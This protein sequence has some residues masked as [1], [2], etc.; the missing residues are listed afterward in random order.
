MAMATPRRPAAAAAVAAAIVRLSAA[1]AFGPGANLTGGGTMPLMGYGCGP[2]LNAETIMEALKVGYRHLDTAFSH[3]NHGVVG[4]AIQRSGVPREEIFLT[5]K[6]GG[7][8]ASQRCCFGL[9]EL[10]KCFTDPAADDPN[11]GAGDYIAGRELA[12]VK[13]ALSELGLNYIDLCLIHRPTVTAMEMHA[14]YLPHYSLIGVITTTWVRRWLQA[15]LDAAVRWEGLL[16]GRAR[17]AAAR[18]ESWRQLEDAKRSGL[19]RHIGLSNYPIGV[20]REMEAYA[21]EPVDVIQ[22][23]YTPI[24]QFPEIYA[25]ARERGIALTGYGTLISTGILGQMLNDTGKRL[26]KTGNQV[27]LRWRLQ[28]GVGLLQGTSNPTRMAENLEVQNFELSREDM[29]ELDALGS[30]RFPV[31]FSNSWHDDLDAGPSRGDAVLLAALATVVLLVLAALATVVRCM[32]GRG[33][34]SGAGRK[35]KST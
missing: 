16:G 9:L 19:C 5:T 2:H 11:A 14:S 12:G 34:G 1:A 24:S 31:Y 27:L 7:L 8:P 4:D 28:N 20:L 23:E 3:Y 32:G 21:R 13:R 33:G 15:T 25:Y 18:A 22:M 6:V 10:P 17:A 35:L 30:H 26:G 29:A